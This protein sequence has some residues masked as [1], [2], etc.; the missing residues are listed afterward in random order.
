MH[1]KRKKK[2]IK[3]SLPEYIFDTFNIIF[4]LLLTFACFYPFYYIIIYSL[5]DPALSSRGLT[6]FPRGFTFN[7][8]IDV[9]QLPNLPRATFNSILRTVVGSTVTVFC[10]TFLGYVVSKENLPFRKIIYRFAIVTM[11]FSA[12]LVP[13]YLTMIAYGFS[14]NFMVYIIPG[15]LSIFFVILV[16]TFIESLPPALEESARIDGAGYLKCFF[17]IIVPLSMPIIATLY[18]FAAVGQWNSFFDNFIFM[19][20]SNHDMHTL[21]F[22]LFNYMRRAEAVASDINSLGAVS[23]AMGGTRRITPMTVR[24]SVTTII[25]LPIL[26]VYP[27]AQRFF[28]KGI[29]IGAI[30]G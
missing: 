30:K 17:H 4:L 7:N 14:N 22:I 10:S 9:F 28:V 12:G 11:Y 15:A 6:F 24:M 23:V 16:K 3:K 8:L 26:F 25:T 20:S 18:V 5:S 2:A 29:M 13:W 27:F 1:T 19:S 21:Q